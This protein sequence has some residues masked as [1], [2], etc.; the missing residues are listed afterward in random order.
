[1]GWGL[2]HS[3]SQ[4]IPL[5]PVDIAVGYF[6]QSFDVGKII[7]ATARLYGFQVSKSF[8][9]LC[10]YGGLGFESATMDIGYTYEEEGVSQP[11]QFELEGINKTRLTLG[12]A[13]DLPVVKLHVDYNMASQN[14]ISGG[15]AFGI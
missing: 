10:L 12:F 5:C 7:K 9:V 11:I 14:V 13:L 15:F 4:Y 2:R 6:Q 8:S 3:I 1:M